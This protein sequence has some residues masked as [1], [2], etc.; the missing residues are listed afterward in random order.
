MEH[1]TIINFIIGLIGTIAFFL[2]IADSPDMGAFI[3]SKILGA[4]I[5]FLDVKAYD[6]FNSDEE[7][8]TV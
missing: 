1:N 6:Y 7:E 2:L 5:L 4:G 3:L 8:E